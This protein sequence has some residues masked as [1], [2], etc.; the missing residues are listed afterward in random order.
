MC[1]AVECGTCKKTTWKGCGKH[2]DQV[3][4]KIKEEDKCPGHGE[5]YEDHLMAPKATTSDSK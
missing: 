2:V 4:G 3:M 1:M 5:P